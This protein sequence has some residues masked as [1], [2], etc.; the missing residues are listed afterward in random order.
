MGKYGTWLIAVS[1]VAPFFIILFQNRAD[2]NSPQVLSSTSTISN[3][4][5][6]VSFG[7][8]GDLG[9][10]RNITAQAR[11]KKDFNWSFGGVT[12]WLTQNDFNLSNLESPIIKDCSTDFKNTMI[13]CGDPQFLPSLK[14]NKFILSLANNHIFNYGQN[15]FTQTKDYLSQNDINF[16][17]S[18]PPVIASDSVAISPNSILTLKQINGIKFGF[19]AY[20]LVISGRVIASDSVAISNDIKK[21]KPEVD[22]LIVSLHWGNEYLSKPE[23]WQI[24]LVHQ[25]I[26]VGADIIAGHHPHVVQP[27]E[28]YKNKLIFYSLGNFIFDQNWSQ[29]TS[30]SEIYRL[31]VSKDKILNIDKT[32]IIIKSNSRPEIRK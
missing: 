25:L 3:N 13:F 22:W 28:T 14:Y 20:D 2:L 8:M 29:A 19:L 23:K 11:L 9:L 30:E 7:L 1:M 31:K 18:D 26:D 12:E 4:E 6:V 15:G 32:P 10:G 5:S 27:V 21:Y 24:D 17:Y 16:V